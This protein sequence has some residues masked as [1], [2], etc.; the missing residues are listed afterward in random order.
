MSGIPP[1]IRNRL[2]T[3]L[4]KCGPFNS[5]YD[6]KAA[7]VDQRLIFWRDELRDANSG[8]S[9]VRTNI[10][11]LYE[12]YNNSGE[13]G[14]ALLLVVLGE[15]QQ[16]GDSCHNELILLANEIGQL[17]RENNENFHEDNRKAKPE[18]IVDY[19]PRLLDSWEVALSDGYWRA[20][21]D[22]SNEMLLRGLR[23]ILVYVLKRHKINQHSITSAEIALMELCRNVARHANTSLGDV[24]IAINLKHQRFSLLVI[25]E[26]DPF[27][28][29]AAL[30]RYQDNSIHGLHN[31]LQRGDILVSHSFGFN[32]VAFHCD[33]SPGESVD[34][35]PNLSVKLTA[36]MIFLGEHKYSYDM[37]YHRLFGSLDIADV[38]DCDDYQLSADYEP[39][40]QTLIEQWSSQ[41]PIPLNVIYEYPPWTLNTL[42]LVITNC[43]D[44]FILVLRADD[45]FEIDEK[46]ISVKKP[47]SAFPPRFLRRSSSHEYSAPVA[48]HDIDLNENQDE[49]EASAFRDITNNSKD[50]FDSEYS[51]NEDV[52]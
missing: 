29:Q 49:T 15:Q 41:S 32:K 40:I 43:F 48:T 17:C 8:I 36:D 23:H 16:V 13:N 52:W 6:L 50:D 46:N 19:N 18:P 28:L 1:Y 5:D 4:L 25:S 47:P 39:S 20:Q 14:L 27:S 31:L 12:R 10:D 30:S 21:I 51:S 11:F 24:D 35:L 22:C 34:N 38:I 33:L 37:W 2:E 9:R 3:V 44:N 26:G 7:F 45:R 42:E